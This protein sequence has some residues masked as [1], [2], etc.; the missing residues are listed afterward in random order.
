MPLIFLF[1]EGWTTAPCAEM[2]TCKKGRVWEAA[3]RLYTSELKAS[4]ASSSCATIA[5]GPARSLHCNS[6]GGTAAIAPAPARSLPHTAELW[7]GS[8]DAAACAARRTTSYGCFTRLVLVG[9]WVRGPPDV[10]LIDLL[11]GRDVVGGLEDRRSACNKRD[12]AL[13]PR[14][15]A[16]SQA[17]AG[18]DRTSK[19]GSGQL[20]VCESANVTSS[21]GE[22]S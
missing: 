10:L 18:S 20:S 2:E 21:S 4:T 19:A 5:G 7:R 9:G 14:C 11:L 13:G 6:G 8:A 16:R 22:P 3:H 12:P 17:D 15:A 1:L